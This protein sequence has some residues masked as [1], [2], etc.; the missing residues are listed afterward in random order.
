MTLAPAT[1]LTADQAP[2]TRLLAR[3]WSRPTLDEITAWASGW[4][5][6]YE[7][8]TLLGLA[9][10]D[11]EALQ[12]ALAGSAGEAL[13]VEHDRLLDGPGRAPC[14]PY[15]SLWRFDGPKREQGRLMGASASDI[16]R[17]YSDI[18][19]RVRTDAHEL[20]DHLVIEW[21]ALAFALENDEAEP[22][23]S[24]L[25]EHLAVWVPS[26]CEAVQAETV[27]P[28]YTALA[29]LTTAWTAALAE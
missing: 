23:A 17:L 28:F 15:E 10:S 20:P 16:A 4:P 13:L 18:G 27:E 26:F 24:L 1:S 25:N 11:L 5:E 19:L 3:W 22:A 21:E 29:S 8:A 12:S 14:P 9:R 7:V 6:A 2:A